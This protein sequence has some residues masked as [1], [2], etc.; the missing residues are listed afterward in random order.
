MQNGD[1]QG[2]LEVLVKSAVYESP[3]LTV[4]GKVSTMTASGS[5]K[6]KFSRVKAQPGPFSQGSRILDQLESTRMIGRGCEI[7][8]MFARPCLKPA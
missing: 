4:Y 8:G 3:R 7:R 6:A 5:D 2:T 1:V